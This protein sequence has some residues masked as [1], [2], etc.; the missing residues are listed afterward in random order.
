MTKKD[1]VVKMN[2]IEAPTYPEISNKYTR[3]FLGGGITNCKD[4]QVDLT[5]HLKSYKCNVFNPRR[6]SFDITDPTVSEEQIR[7][8]KYFLSESDI[9]I[10]YFSSE[11]L[12]PITL[13]ELGARLSS[14]LYRDVEDRQSIY[15][16]CEQNYARKFDVE[17]QTK[18]FVDGF[19]KAKN[20][21]YQLFSETSDDCIVDHTNYFDSGYDVR[22][23]DDYDKFVQTIQSQI[24]KL[25]THEQYIR[26]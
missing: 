19:I 14:N 9:V 8:E 13:F 10:F 21:F 7:W 1:T 6:K 20:T 11:T 5:N 2:Y 22:C 23:F 17:F 24:E 26:I 12:C 25:N 3:V 16:Y 4:W 18:L 15:I